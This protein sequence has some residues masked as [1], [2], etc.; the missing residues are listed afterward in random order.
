[1]PKG[2]KHSLETINKMKLVHKGKTYR[3][4][5]WKHS[6]KVRI[7]MSKI[8]K[9]K[10]FGKWLIGIHLSDE[11]KEQIR[12][13]QTGKRHTKKSKEK[14]RQI[15]LNRVK[16]GKHNWYKGGRRK[17][18]LG[19]VYIL[20]PTHPSCDTMGYVFEH[21]LTVEKQIDRYLTAKEVVH[22]INKITNDN[23]IKNLMAFA[24]NSAHRRFEYN[25]NNVK[26]SEIIFDGRTL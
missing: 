19:Y 9:E 22:H 18:S 16:E 10:G 15:A 5:G 20:I 26:P 4:K 17:H 25:S 1:M 6:K 14:M 24:T 8:A 13:T 2:F 21:R 23:R 3:S 11:R 7:K 12:L